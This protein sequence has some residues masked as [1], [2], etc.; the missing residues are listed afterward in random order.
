V[1]LEDNDH[2]GPSR[3]HDASRCRTLPRWLLAF[4]SPRRLK[5]L[6]KPCSGVPS[7][8]TWRRPRSAGLAMPLVAGWNAL[9]APDSPSDR[10]AARYES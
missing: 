8:S 10:A 5:H 4:A 1:F 3:G 2:L 6:P 9:Y 7:R